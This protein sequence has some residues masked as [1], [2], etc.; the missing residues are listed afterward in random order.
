MNDEELSKMI[1]KRDTKA[2]EYMM[3]KYNKLLWIVIGNV[4]EKVGFQEDIE[5]CISNVYLKILEK[6]SL[7]DPNKGS[8]K[9]FL[10]KVGKNLAIDRYRHLSKSNV[11]DIDF[12]DHANEEIFDIIVKNENR[13]LVIQAIESLK[14]PDRE[15][16]IRRFYFNE[17]P[18]VIS[19]KMKLQTKEVENRL[20]Q[21]KIRLKKIISGQE[22]QVQNG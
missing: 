10:V 15:I 9:S 5:D 22:V 16:L 20:Y 2:F 19:D 14:E 3:T 7:Y 1:R 11:I 4:L 12:N 8:L 17:K 18:S 21:G 6:P 13:K